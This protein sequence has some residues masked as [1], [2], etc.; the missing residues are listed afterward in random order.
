MK[1][2]SLIPA[3]LARSVKAIR[4]CMPLSPEQAREGAREYGGPVVRVVDTEVPEAL[5]FRTIVMQGQQGSGKSLT[6][7]DALV[8]RLRLLRDPAHNERLVI[9]D[10]KGDIIRLVLGAR[11][12]LCPNA[13]V[14]F[15]NP[16]ERF[17]VAPDPEELTANPIKIAQLVSALTYRRRDARTDDFF[18]SM[19]RNHLVALLKAFRRKVPGRWRWRDLYHVATSYELHRKVLGAS[20][21]GRQKATPK[22]QKTF[23][24][25]VST[26][27]GWL[28]AY[29]T[30]FAC[31]ERSPRFRLNAFLRGRGIAIISCPEDQHEAFTPVIRMLLRFTRDRLLADTGNDPN[32]F[33]TIV[34][35][36]FADLEGMVPVILPFFGKSRSA[37]VAMLLA[38]QSWPAACLAHGETEMKS[39]IDNAAIRVYFQSGPESVEVAARDCLQTEVERT[40]WSHGFDRQEPFGM[41]LFDPRS[42]TM[43]VRTELRP[44]VLPG[45]I[46]KLGLPSKKNPTVRAYMR[47]AHLPGPVL[48][49]QN[50]GPLIEFCNALPVVPAFR[51]RGGEMWLDPWDDVSD[52]A[53]L[54]TLF[55]PDPGLYEAETDEFL[56][57]IDGGA[58]GSDTERC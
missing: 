33:T 9:I 10:M 14:Y 56:P 40:E 48:C 41:G 32:S 4:G 51:E 53:R 37:N 45:E 52:G 34:M 35:D 26:I 8:P 24:G 19:G 44:N 31:W 58:E 22:V 29:E 27:E 12:V 5:R 50:Y 38:W 39:I 57:I 17:G 13:P 7:F 49:A 6:T 30:A 36:E 28:G 1:L 3:S 11:K 42:A 47:A 15:L 2:P 46:A 20:G 16:A 55:E 54:A 23:A 18:D 25:V 43:S 21:E